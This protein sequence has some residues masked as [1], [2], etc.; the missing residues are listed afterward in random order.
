MIKIK[1]N[2]DELIDKIS[3]FYK[4]DVNHFVTISGY[5]DKSGI[6]LDYIFSNYSDEEV[7][8]FTLK[9]DYD[10]EVPTITKLIP[11]SFIAEEEN[12]DLLGVKF[13]NAKGGLFLDE[14]SPKTPL[15]KAK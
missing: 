13:E 10:V 9:I 4:E 6:V 15:R 1:I 14:E 3:Q 2:L 8:I 5:D 11:S 7:T 12:F